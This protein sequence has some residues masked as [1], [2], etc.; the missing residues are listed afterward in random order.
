MRTLL[1]TFLIAA[2]GAVS[3]AKAQEPDTA[4][5]ESAAPAVDVEQ[6]HNEIRALRDALI[7]AVNEKDVDSLLPLLHENVILTAQDGDQL[8]TIRGRDGIRDYLDRLLTGPDAGVREMTVSPVVDDLTILY[9]DD[10]GVAYGSSTD[11]YVLR[12]GSK[13]TL[14]T[15]WNATVVRAADGWQLA[16]LQVSSNLFDNPVLKSLTQLISLASGIAAVAGIAIGFALASFFKR[17][18]QTSATPS[19]D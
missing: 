3:I 10:A 14:K 6:T 12:D 16:S 1:C 13:F 5:A 15:R 11:E 2:L 17:R 8:A 18:R 4:A 9:G 7:K 19:A